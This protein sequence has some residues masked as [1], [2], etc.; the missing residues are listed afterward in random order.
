MTSRFRR[1]AIWLLSHPRQVAMLQLLMIIQQL[2]DEV[3]S[4]RGELEQQAFRMKKMERQQLDRYRDLDRRIST[5][6]RNQERRR[7]CRCG[8]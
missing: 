1:R 4:L 2:Q 3:R 5:L 7:T 6:M 8:F